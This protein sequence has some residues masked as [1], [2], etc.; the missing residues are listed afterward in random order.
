LEKGTIKSELTSVDGIGFS[1]AQ[2][3]LWK[4]RSVKKIKEAKLDELTKVVGKS[5]A[6]IVFSHFSKK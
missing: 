5:K 4:F 1:T 2:K 6:E 3:L